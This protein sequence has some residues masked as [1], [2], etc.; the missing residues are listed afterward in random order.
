MHAIKTILSALAAAVVG[1]TAQSATVVNE[2]AFDIYILSTPVN[3]G[4]PHPAPSPV[5]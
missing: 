5:E 3:G 1:T 2:C 4:N